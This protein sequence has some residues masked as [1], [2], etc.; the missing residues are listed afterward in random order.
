MIVGQTIYL[1]FSSFETSLLS[2]IAINQ[3]DMWGWKVRAMHLEGN[4]VIVKD[5]VEENWNKESGNINSLMMEKLRREM[6]NEQFF[7]TQSLSHNLHAFEVNQPEKLNDDLLFAFDA[8]DRPNSKSP[9]GR[10]T[11]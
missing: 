10:S 8:Q 5:G 11:P 1:T 2:M 4:A 3:M 9:S 6:I 7:A